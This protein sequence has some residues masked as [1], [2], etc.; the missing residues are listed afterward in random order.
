MLR[1]TVPIASVNEYGYLCG[2]E[3]QVSRPAKIRQRTRGYAV[4]QT[5]RMH[6]AAD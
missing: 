5:L 1:T 3:D 2:T 6:E 4:S